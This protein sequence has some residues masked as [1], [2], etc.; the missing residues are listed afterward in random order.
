MRIGARGLLAACLGAIVVMFGG[1]VRADVSSTNPAGLIV[2]PRLVFNSAESF[3]TVLQVS[4]TADEPVHVRCYLVNANG[5]CSNQPDAVCTSSEDCEGGLCLPGW[6]E[7]DFIFTLT[8]NQPIVWRL[9]VGLSA[10][11]L[12]G[13]NAVGPGGEFNANSNIPP[14]PEDPFTGEL[15]CFQVDENDN[16]VARNDL[17]GEA[18]YVLSTEELDAYAYNAVGIQATEFNDGDDTLCLGGT[19]PTDECP[20]PEYNGCPNVLILNHFF[21]YAPE[22][23]VGN[24]VLTHL[25]LVPCSEDFLNQATVKSTLQFL[26]FNEYEQRFSTSNR[27]DCYVETQLAD[28]DTRPGPSDDEFSIFSV[29]VQGTLTGQTRVRPVQTEETEVGHGY[30]GIARE[31]H[32]GPVGVYSAAFQLHQTGIRR[33]GD[34][35]RVPR[36]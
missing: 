4:N 6:T 2:F 9:G 34:I 24:V 31:T 26:V 36:E 10:F 23:I 1:A 32:Y 16:P 5:H 35:V 20:E 22:P 11:P 12:D 7:T 27:V 3:D 14:A 13:I 8:R 28:I 19:E 15:K 25:Q 33:Q 29:F 17:K 30:V 21:E 18:T